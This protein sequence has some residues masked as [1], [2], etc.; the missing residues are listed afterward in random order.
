MPRSKYRSQL[1]R[2][3]V[4]RFYHLGNR[5]IAQH[6]IANYG[7]LFDNDIEKARHAVRKIVGANGR[8]HRESVPAELF[9]DA[10][11]ALPRTWAKP[12][13]D[14]VLPVGLWLVLNDIHI[15]FHEP[16]PLEAALQYGKEQKVTGVLLNG[17]I[18]DYA[19]VGFWP[20]L[21]RDFAEEIEAQIDFFDYL[22]YLFPEQPIV[23]KPGN[24]E[25]RLPRYYV[26][27]APELATTPLA[28]METVLGLE[29]RKIEFLDYK[30]AV[31][32]GGLLIFHGDEVQASSP[33]NP[34]R[35]LFLKTNTSALCGHYH[36]TSEHTQRNARGQLV[37][38]W[39][40]GCLCNLNPEYSPFGNWNWGF[41]LVD[42]YKEGDTGGFEVENR[43]I[44]P[45]GR[46]K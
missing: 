9:R 15:P 46:I 20:G 8:D 17:D 3:T 43:R 13:Q 39:S 44:L 32:A 31:R 4:R 10:I 11:T 42:V 26:T 23:W 45:S 29:R 28:A 38:N 1:V 33:V 40:V 25:Y 36:R 14:H 35:G 16:D 7:E 21:K 19:G 30:Q 12:R 22:R 41:A 37:T 2:D 27:Y 24:H 18:A 6:L 34:A 5:T